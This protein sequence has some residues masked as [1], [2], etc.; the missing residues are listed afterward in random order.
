MV[1]GGSK[2]TGHLRRWARSPMRISAPLP[3]FPSKYPNYQPADPCSASNMSYMIKYGPF[4]PTTSN[5]WFPTNP[6]AAKPT[7]P[8]PSQRPHLISW[9]EITGLRFRSQTGTPGHSVSGKVFSNLTVV[10]SRPC[11]CIRQLPAVCPFC[12]TYG[13]SG[14]TPELL[15]PSKPNPA[16]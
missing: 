6:H 1:L 2:T 5:T 8:G 13:T 11:Q 7:L 15:Q 14:C 10:I 4:Q 12:C 3:N 16:S 9:I